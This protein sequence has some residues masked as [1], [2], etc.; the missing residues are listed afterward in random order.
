M[1]FKG[2][3]HTMLF[4]GLKELESKREQE[5]SSGVNAKVATRI[6]RKVFIL[7]ASISLHLVGSK[8]T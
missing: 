5:L 3:K 6:V 7:N 1:V 4:A 2:E 8:Q